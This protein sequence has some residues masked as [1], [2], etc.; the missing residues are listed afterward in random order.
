MP[1][2]LQ[3]AF[4]DGSSETVRLPIEMWKLG[5]VYTYRVGAGRGVTG[6]TLDPR[7]VLPDVDRSNNGWSN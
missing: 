7:E 1:A 2:E 5:P 6:V 4:A 3:I